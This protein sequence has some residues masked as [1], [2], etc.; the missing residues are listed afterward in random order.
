MLV[1][2]VGFTFTSVAGSIGEL[3]CFADTMTSV[4]SARLCAYRADIIAPID[5][6]V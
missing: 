1:I 4:E 2:A 6:S 3:P 5:W